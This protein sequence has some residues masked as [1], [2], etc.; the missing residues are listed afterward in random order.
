[1]KLVVFRPEG[2]QDLAQGKAYSP[3]P[4]VSMHPNHLAALKGQ[5][6]AQQGFRQKIKG[7]VCRLGAAIN[8]PEWGSAPEG[9]NVYNRRCQP[10]AS[11]LSRSFSPNGALLRELL[12]PFGALRLGGCRFPPVDTG[13]YRHFAPSGQ[14]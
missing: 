7:S 9:R 10:A 13:G 2:A 12:R 5:D 8:R 3:P 14:V 1:M 11:G 6:T 4:W